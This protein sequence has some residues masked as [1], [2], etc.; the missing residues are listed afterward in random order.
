MEPMETWQINVTLYPEW[1]SGTVKDIRYPDTERWD[2][3]YTF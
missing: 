1:D 3:G 2:Y